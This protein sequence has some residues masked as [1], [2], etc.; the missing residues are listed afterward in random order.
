MLLKVHNLLWLYLTVPIAS[1]TSER[2]FSALS[3]VLSYLRSSSSEQRLN[4]CMSLH[5]HKHLTDSGDIKEISK[6]FIA[7]NIE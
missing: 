3:R 4:N 2:S 5:I 1:A 7:V 6:E